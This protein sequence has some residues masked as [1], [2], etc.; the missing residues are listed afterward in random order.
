MQDQAD[1]IR[2]MK[3]E[4]YTLKSQLYDTKAISANLPH[5]DLNKLIPFRCDEDLI[6]CLD[7]TNLN[8]ALFSKVLLAVHLHTKNLL[9][10]FIIQ[11]IQLP[12]SCPTF[13][14]SVV[15]LLFHPDYMAVRSWPTTFGR[16]PKPKMPMQIRS[17]MQSYVTR[18]V[19]D[20]MSPKT[21]MLAYVQTYI[22]HDAAI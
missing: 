1:L 11:A 5:K 17:F 2:E 18:H 16:S 21:F 4:L 14:N 20:K 10:H 19:Q 7:D 12:A 9:F 3:H 6:T 15:D 8:N 13:V 22:Y